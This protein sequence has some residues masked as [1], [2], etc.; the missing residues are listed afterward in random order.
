MQFRASLREIAQIRAMSLEFARVRDPLHAPVDS[1]RKIDTPFPL[2]AEPA[3]V[4]L[5]VDP[6]G[7]ANGDNFAVAKAAFLGGMPRFRESEH[8][9]VE[10]EPWGQYVDTFEVADGIDGMG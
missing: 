9:E 1:S 7:F 2:Y 6:N 3:R 10:T 4:T 8:G 5:W